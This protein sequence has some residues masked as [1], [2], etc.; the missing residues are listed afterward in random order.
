[1]DN[2]NNINP[3][4]QDDDP[5]R[6]II[7]LSV[8]AAA[9]IGCCV[10]FLAAFFYFQPDQLSQVARYF[11]SATA[12]FTRTP[13]TTPTLTF[14][15]TLTPTKTSTPSPT[16]TPTPH[17]LLAAPQDV[18]VLEETFDSNSR[19]W[20]PYYSNNTLRVKDGK[21]LIKS[22]ETG[23]I[24]IAI[25]IDCMDYEQ[26]LYLQAELLLDEGTSHQHGLAFCAASKDNEFY[27]FMI[28]QKNSYYNLY[29]HRGDEWETLIGNARTD[30]INKYPA[31][32]TLGVYFDQGK[33][34]LYIN[35]IQVESYTDDSP[36]QCSWAGVI[37]DD[38]PLN[39]VA[40]NVFSYTVKP[41]P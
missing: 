30:A 16:I 28:N 4:D 11:P 12:T 21:L 24:G 2:N 5:R 9:F 39:L 19:G 36:F 15:P 26:T 10:V 37:I 22:D 32:N 41:T 14:T 6:R 38:G 34:E 35:N 7:L 8:S 18:T 20:D 17:L 23:F 31:S 1:M 3:F 25:C 40:D 27:T 29:K 33:M 13:T